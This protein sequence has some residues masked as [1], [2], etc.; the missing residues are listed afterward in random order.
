MGYQSLLFCPDEKLASVVSQVFGE[1]DFTVEPVHEPFAAVKKLMTQHYDAIVVDTEN[2]QNA[3][4]LFKS[5]RN[6]SS[7]QNSLAIALVEGQTG[8]AKAYRIGANLVLTKPINVEQAKGTLRVARGLLRKTSDA[9]SATAAV[10]ATPASPTPVAAGSATQPDR[11]SAARMAFPST[12][13]EA[14][15]SETPQP[16]LI[17][18]ARPAE[19]SGELSR[20]TAVAKL[21][22]KPAVA[23]ASATPD[24]IA[25]AAEAGVKAWQHASPG[26]INGAINNEVVEHNVTKN[27]IKSEA[28]T[29]LAASGSVTARN[30]IFTFPSLTGSAA[31]PAPA[32]EVT[33]P[34]PGKNRIVES[35][36]AGPPHASPSHDGTPIPPFSSMTTSD[37]PSVAGVG[38][39]D[40]GGSDA[41]KKMVIAAAIVL[42]LAALGYLGYGMLVKSSTTPHSI[43]TPQST[44]QDSERTAPVLVPQSSPVAAPSAS[45]PSRASAATPSDK[46]PTGTNKSLVI[47]MEANPG[48]NAA[49]YTAANSELET[50]KPDSSP[51]VVKSN[52][53]VTRTQAKAEES[54]PPLP[55]SL[56][57]ASANQ[58]DL[59]SVMSSPSSSLPKLSLTTPKISQGVSEGLLIKRVQPKYPQAALAIHA[60]GAVQIEATINKEGFVTNPKVLSG[61]TVLARAALEA[62]RQWRYKPYYLDGVPVEIQT[63]I[64]VNFRTN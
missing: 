10:P 17:P 63:Q 47:L 55:G 43:S 40:S 45:T 56:A 61:A 31:A 48:A 41:N 19:F 11:R 51:L 32:K 37:A 29:S 16:T 25:I 54:A 3:S 23:L 9:A 30:S 39:E 59:S 6:S 34:P 15:D 38:E 64:T 53:T 13:P 35:E 27:A 58:G 60:Q 21:E 8:V 18:E 1:L 20:T 14:P 49:A 4:L 57:V 7:N 52:A 36:P 12:R 46:P 42:A 44:P 2:E 62:V 24:Q 22:D 28:E 26:V 33:V 5:A 50:K